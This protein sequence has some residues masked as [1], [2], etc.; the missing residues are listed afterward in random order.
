MLTFCNKGHFMASFNVSKYSCAL[1]KIKE[2][3]DSSNHYFMYGH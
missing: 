2:Y 1:L 3:H